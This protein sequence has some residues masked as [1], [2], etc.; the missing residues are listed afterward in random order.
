[1]AL[2]LRDDVAFA[3]VEYGMA[4]LDEDSGE[5]WNLN[6]TGFLVL[7]T[8]LAGGTV[9]TAVDELAKGYDLERAVLSRDVEDLVSELH[10][11]G[12]IEE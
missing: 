11:A 3:E 7:Q 6:P 12:L 5:Y 2:R 10:S 1:M 4:L 8:L 9:A